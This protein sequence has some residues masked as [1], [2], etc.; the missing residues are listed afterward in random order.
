MKHAQARDEEQTEEHTQKPASNEGIKAVSIQA[1]MHRNPRYFYTR[2]EHPSSY[3]T[4][5]FK[6]SSVKRRRKSGISL[7]EKSIF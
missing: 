2:N 4:A 6:M 5:F 1:P 3:S 7:A